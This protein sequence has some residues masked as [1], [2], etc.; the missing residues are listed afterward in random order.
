MDRTSILRETCPVVDV[1]TRGQDTGST[2]LCPLEL[3][4]GSIEVDTGKDQDMFR[5]E[6]MKDTGHRTGIRDRRK[7]IRDQL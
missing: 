5:R 1:L 7:L 6:N 2:I 3:I 4:F